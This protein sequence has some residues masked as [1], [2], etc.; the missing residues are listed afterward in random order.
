[1]LLSCE[2]QRPTYKRLLEL[3]QGVRGSRA[4]RGLLERIMSAGSRGTWDDCADYCSEEEGGW[5]GSSGDGG[6]LHEGA[7]APCAGAEGAASTRD[8]WRGD[9]DIVT[10]EPISRDIRLDAVEELRRLLRQP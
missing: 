8:G 2:D 3:L 7:A 1:M 9:R 5:E 4:S 10:N 6:A